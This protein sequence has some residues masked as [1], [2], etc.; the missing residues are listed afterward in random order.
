MIMSM[1]PTTVPT[2]L[3]KDRLQYL[4]QYSSSK[5]AVY[6]DEI[7]QTT[8]EKISTHELATAFHLYQIE[9]QVDKEQ[10]ARNRLRNGS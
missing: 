4:D 1:L 5:V 10:A 6:L 7:T 8:Q 2:T 9:R 3:P